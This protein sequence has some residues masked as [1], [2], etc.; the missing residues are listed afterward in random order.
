MTT[1]DATSAN[2]PGFPPFNHL[3]QGGLVYVD[4]PDPD[5]LAEEAMA[6]KNVLEL[7]IVTNTPPVKNWL[8]DRSFNGAT[9]SVLNHCVDRAAQ[10]GRDI[11][12]L[13]RAG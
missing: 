13:A 3:S 6:I 7:L 9:L 12:R 5:R 10:L 2:N 1:N 4:L 8:H 11:D